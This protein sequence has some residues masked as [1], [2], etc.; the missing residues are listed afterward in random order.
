M[1]PSNNEGMTNTPEVDEGDLQ[2][3]A[4]LFPE[5]DQAQLRRAHDN[6]R[7]YV[8]LAVRIAA[9]VHPDVLH[10]DDLFDGLASASYDAD[11][12]VETPS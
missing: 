10:D 12:K 4:A 11:T 2:E 6:L 5:L 8:A 3:L 7:R 9:R 1:N